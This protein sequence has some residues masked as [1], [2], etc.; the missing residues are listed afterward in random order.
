MTYDRKDWAAETVDGRR[1][2]NAGFRMLPGD[3]ADWELIKAIP[4]EASLGEGEFVYMWQRREGLELLRV[5]V[6]E[7]ADWR[8]AQLRLLEDLRMSMRSDIP[9]ATGKLG[10]LGD[11]AY[12]AR[13]AESDIPASISFARGNVCASVRSVGDREADASDA[14]L[15]LDEALG[16][17]PGRGAE[18]GSR[19]VRE[20]RREDVRPK[21]AGE[22]SVIVRNVIDLARDAWLQAVADEGELVRRDDALVHVA[23]GPEA[24]RIDLYTYEAP[25]GRERPPDRPRR[26]RTR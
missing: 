18:R 19:H 2:F 24:A 23:T 25:L 4:F 21:R 16:Q 15:W 22:E 10:H 6:A 17:P 7:L 1:V 8:S 3:L 13:S 12:A 26:K 11:I 14:A 5:Q 20:R 9:R